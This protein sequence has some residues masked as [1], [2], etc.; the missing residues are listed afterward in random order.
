[1]WRVDRCA[2]AGIYRSVVTWVIEADTRVRA[3]GSRCVEI[4]VTVHHRVSMLPN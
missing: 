3:Q 4:C 2:Y 1:M